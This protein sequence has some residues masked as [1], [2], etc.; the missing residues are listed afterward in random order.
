MNRARTNNN[1]NNNNNNSKPN[2]SMGNSASSS[3]LHDHLN[4]NQTSDV[5]IN[6]ITV[7]HHHSHNNNNNKQGLRNASSFSDILTNIQSSSN[8]PIIKATF[9][10]IAWAIASS[11]LIFLNK[12]LMSS[13]GFH[14]PMILCSMGVLAS[15]AISVLMIKTGFAEFTQRQ[16]ITV[17]WYLINV[18]PI[19]LFAAMSLGFG[20]Y[21]YL[22]LSVS[23]I[24]MLKACVP[25]VTLFVM[26]IAGLEKLDQRVLL[27]VVVLTVGTTMS[28]YGEI[29]FKWVGVVMMVT[30]EFCEAIRMAVLQYL[31]GN[32]RFELVEGLYLFAPAS[33]FCLLLGIMWLEFPTFMRENGM[34]KIL[35]NPAL[36]FTAAMLGFCVNYLTL[37]VIKS[38]SGLTFK[39][40]GQAKNTM[41]IFLSVLLFGSTVT[42][43]QIVGYSISMI[44]FYIYQIGK[45]AQTARENEEKSMMHELASQK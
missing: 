7:E 13:A 15:W 1:N 5:D 8:Y 30:S 6:D 34:L 26:F 36:Y 17:R 2:H 24:Q 20:N 45:M 40:L 28:A 23:F 18:M 29:D 33:L 27:G 19:G 42:G 4:K 32:L 31:L 37:G 41:V 12:Y 22:Y 10:V 9:F 44:G 39:V 11:S 25:A 38:T 3:P 14:Y 16:K 43:L 35:E 21:V